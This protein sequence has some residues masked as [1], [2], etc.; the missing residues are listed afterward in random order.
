MKKRPASIYS[1]LTVFSKNITDVHI[2][3]LSASSF[4]FRCCTPPPSCVKLLLK[5]VLMG[6][7]DCAVCWHHCLDDTSLNNS[8]HTSLKYFLFTA[9]RTCVLFGTGFC[10][11]EAFSPNVC[12]MKTPKLTGKSLCLPDVL[13]SE[14]KC[15]FIK[16]FYI[17]RVCYTLYSAAD[18]DRNQN[19][20]TVLVFNQ[21]WVLTAD[22]SKGWMVQQL[23]KV[24]SNMLN[25]YWWR[26][27]S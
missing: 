26:S 9:G 8:S 19:E 2:K 20:N 6:T 10:H 5:K 18:K 3:H 15:T 25:G 22:C 27:Q 7:T 23:L 21:K 13:I 14:T 17:R 11:K 4:H 12:L 16:Q 1:N 24:K